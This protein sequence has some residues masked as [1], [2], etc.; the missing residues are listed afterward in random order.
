MAGRVKQPLGDLFGLSNF[1]VNMTTLEPGAISALHHCHSKQDEFI[2]ILSGEAVLHIGESEE[3]MT[4]G[5][6]MGFSAGGAAH[7]LENRSTEP[8]TYLEI[9]DR[10]QGDVGTYPNDDLVAKHD[11]EKWVF[12]RKDG[13]QI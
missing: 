1:G 3:I 7:H 10:T 2:Y 4:P 9:G 11:G 5:M 12:E 8:V 13:R 6:V